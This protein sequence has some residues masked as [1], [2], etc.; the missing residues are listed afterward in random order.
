MGLSLRFS[1]AAIRIQHSDFARPKVGILACITL[2]VCIGCASVRQADHHSEQSRINRLPQ[3]HSV[4]SPVELL[5][6]RAMRKLLIQAGY[7]VPNEAEFLCSG[8]NWCTWNNW[9]FEF[10]TGS[11]R[12]R[13]M[14]D[15]SELKGFTPVAGDSWPAESASNGPTDLQLTKLIDL[16]QEVSGYRDLQFQT[17]VHRWDESRGR[18]QSYQYF[19]MAGQCRIFATYDFRTGRLL[20]Y[21]WSEGIGVAPRLAR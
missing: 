13:S 2:G 10:S 7:T 5:R 1:L 21:A 14:V 19:S 15:W 11:D 3:I 16:L 6:A 8:E 20:E 12:V 9:I 4:N 18:I 17:R